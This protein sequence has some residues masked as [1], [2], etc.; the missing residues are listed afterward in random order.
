MSPAAIHANIPS[1]AVT[2]PTATPNG[3]AWFVGA[4]NQAMDKY[5]SAARLNDGTN[6]AVPAAAELH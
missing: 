1:Q 6:S 3:Q 2:G 4:F 5:Q